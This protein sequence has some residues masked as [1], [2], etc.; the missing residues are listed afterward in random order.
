MTTTAERVAN[1][2]C[3]F[4]LSQAAAADLSGALEHIDQL[5]SRAGAEAIA[6]QKWDDRR[7]AFE[8]DKQRRGVFLLYYFSVPTSGIAQLDRDVNISEII[9]RHMVI[10]ADHL[11]MDQMQAMDDRDGLLAEAKMRAERADEEDAGQRRAQVL[12]REEQEARAKAEADAE[13]ARKAAEAPAEDAPADAAADAS[14]EAD[15]P[16]DGETKPADDTN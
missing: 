5:L 16:T 4:L 6:M 12:T 3:M 7:L 14:T 11:T 9:M 2:E 1:Y 15:A 13:A 10:R 8:I